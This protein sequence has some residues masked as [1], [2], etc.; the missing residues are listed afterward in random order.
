MPA[1]NPDAENVGPAANSNNA[2]RAA[3]NLLAIA[4][5]EVAGRDAMFSTRSIFLVGQ[6]GHVRIYATGAET[7]VHFADHLSVKGVIADPM[8]TLTTAAA[9]PVLR[10]CAVIAT[11]VVVLAFKVIRMTAGTIGYES[12]VLPVDYL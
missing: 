8:A 7:V 10:D 12:G 5:S 6:V 1:T 4:A 9:V 3:L 11:D 2:A